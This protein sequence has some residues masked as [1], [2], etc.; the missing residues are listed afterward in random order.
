MYRKSGSWY[1]S[2][3]TD[4]RVVTEY[5]GRGPAADAAA[6]RDAEH[7]QQQ[8]ATR[9]LYRDELKVDRQIDR[10]DRSV[11]SL[12]AAALICSGHHRHRGQWRRRRT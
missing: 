2:Q 9:D 12:A 7:R 11:R 1:R 10:V 8:K 4:G 3:R 5:V 6:S